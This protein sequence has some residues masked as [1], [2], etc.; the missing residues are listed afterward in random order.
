MK[1]VIELFQLGGIFMYPLLLCSIIGLGVIFERLWVIHRARINTSEFIKN[2]LSALR[3]KGVEAAC[4]LCE[5]TKGPI[6]TAL[7][8]GLRRV[9]QGVANV[10][11]AIESAATVEISLLERGW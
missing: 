7:H 4:Q 8:A 1:P 11:E 6:A 3:G 2:L 10:E 9:A 5:K